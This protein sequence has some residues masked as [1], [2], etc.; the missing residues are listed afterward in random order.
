MTYKQKKRK[1]KMSKNAPKGAMSS[2]FTGMAEQMG[3]F[4]VIGTRRVEA[5]TDAQLD[6]LV[7][8]LAEIGTP[9]AKLDENRAVIAEI[10]GIRVKIIKE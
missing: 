1:Q 6:E 2:P 4:D 3:G 7:P 8:K 10:C 5:F 9:I